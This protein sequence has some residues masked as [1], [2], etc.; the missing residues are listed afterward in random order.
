VYNNSSVDN[1]SVDNS[2]VDN[3][4]VDNSSVYNEKI[5]NTKQIYTQSPIG[6]RNDRCTSVIN[7]EKVIHV[8][9]GC[10]SGTIE[11][12]EKAVLKT[13]GHSNYG[14]E[15]LAYIQ[16]AETHFEIWGLL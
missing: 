5:T 1:S 10:F 4:S 13:H 14:K 12:F 6:S 9:T 8:R 15:Y 7:E 16:N 2:S 11:E 3:S